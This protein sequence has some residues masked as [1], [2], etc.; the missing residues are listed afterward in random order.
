VGLGGLVVPGT[1]SDSMV[2]LDA[3]FNLDVSTPPEL[4]ITDNASYSDIVFGLFAICGYQ[5]APRIADISDARL[6]RIKTKPVQPGERAQV[7]PA[8]SYGALDAVSRNSISV[9]TIRANWE[10]M[11]RVAGSL[12]TGQVRAL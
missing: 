3:I 9:R 12:T 2:I 6:W 11:L 5:F 10:D 4:I 1:L 8:A 7:Q